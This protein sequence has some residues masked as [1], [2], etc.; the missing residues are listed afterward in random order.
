MRNNSIKKALDARKERLEREGWI[1]IKT[2]PKF[3]HYGKP[4]L[5]SEN[6]TIKPVK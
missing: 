3:R 1:K 5:I 4:C 2:E 6:G